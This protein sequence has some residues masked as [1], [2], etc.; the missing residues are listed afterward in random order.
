MQAK[1]SSIVVESSLNHIKSVLAMQE[2]FKEE[3]M[4]LFS[5]EQRLEIVESRITAMEKTLLLHCVM[6]LIQ[7][8]AEIEETEEL[9]RQIDFQGR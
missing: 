9:L 3:N 7:S 8:G 2:M 1:E 6:A 4:K 5:V